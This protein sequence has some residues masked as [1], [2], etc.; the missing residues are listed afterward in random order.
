M[1]NPDP[2]HPQA[3]AAGTPAPLAGSETYRLEAAPTGPAADLTANGNHAVQRWEQW[4]TRTFPRSCF[5]RTD[6]SD[7]ASASGEVV[8]QVKIRTGKPG[9][10]HVTEDAL[11]LDPDAFAEV[12]RKLEADDW[13]GLVD[14]FVRVRIKGNGTVGALNHSA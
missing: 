7:A 14:Q 8:W 3:D 6:L 4:L 10:V 12:T 1:R 13:F 5:R 11:H 2:S 9:R